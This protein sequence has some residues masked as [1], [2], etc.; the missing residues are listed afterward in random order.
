MQD[1]FLDNRPTFATLNL[2]EHEGKAFHLPYLSES[3]VI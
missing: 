2:S 1:L 3:L